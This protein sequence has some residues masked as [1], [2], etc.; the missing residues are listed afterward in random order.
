[1]RAAS[2]LFWKFF[3]AIWAGYVLL[4]GIAAIVFQTQYETRYSSIEVG[5]R[6]GPLANYII[7]RYEQ[8]VDIS[9]R[10]FRQR[11]TDFDS[12]EANDDLLVIRDLQRERVIFGDRD[13]SE[14][15]N[16]VD[17]AI[18]S[19]TGARY[20]ANVGIPPNRNPLPALTTPT[21]ISAAL[22]TSLIYSW[23]FTFVLT[24]PITRLKAHVQSLGR[25]ALDQKLEGSLMRRRDEIGDLATSIDEMS[26]YIQQLLNSKQ[27]LLFD[28]SHELR[29]PLARMQVAAG[30]ARGE[31]ESAGANTEMH[32]RFEHEIE[33]LNALISELLLLAKTENDVGDTQT[34]LLAD[35]LK[36]IVADMEFG[37]GDREI[38]T[39]IS[40]TEA[41]VEISVPLFGR[42]VKNLIE[43]SLKYSQ[44]EVCVYLDEVDSNWVI[45]V[46]DRGEGIPEEQIQAMTQPFTRLQS[47]SIEGFGLGLSIAHRAASAIGGSLTL[48]NREKGGLRATLTLPK[49]EVS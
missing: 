39:H 7:A 18:V 33:T 10:E 38:K 44:G 42:V 29:A 14:R 8:G 16:N 28:V 47:E 25:G 1:M 11:E 49:S 31:A 20:M 35:E 23:L 4:I 12:G 37:A 41:E 48:E 32:D 19:D 24:S 34:I 36:S 2:S 22:I 43:N 46:E 17:F 26:E 27:R 40:V 21:A 6:Y 9:R 30:I 45:R 15:P 5:A 13:G 3:L